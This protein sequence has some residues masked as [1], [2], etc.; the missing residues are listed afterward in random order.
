MSSS[1]EHIVRGTNLLGNS[2]RGRNHPLT[3][4]SLFADHFFLFPYIIVKSRVATPFRFLFPIPFCRRSFVDAHP[5]TSPNAWAKATINKFK[6]FRKPIVY[7]PETKRRLWFPRRQN[8]LFSR[9]IQVIIYHQ[10]S[11]TSGMQSSN[12]EISLNQ[13]W[14]AFWQMR[15]PSMSGR[16]LGCRGIQICSFN[17]TMVL[18]L[19]RIYWPSISLTGLVIA[20]MFIYLKTLFD[21]SALKIFSWFTSQLLVLRINGS[22]YFQSHRCIHCEGHFLGGF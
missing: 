21:R 2:K 15:I 19:W 7:Y 18:F 6:I 10:G 13:S 17:L 3:L 16:S 12:A 5:P 1:T 11:R 8:Q 20:R 22:A 14:V 9:D 4:D